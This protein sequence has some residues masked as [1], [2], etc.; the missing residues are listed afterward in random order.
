MNK[1]IC[2]SLLCV[3]LHATA[4][5]PFTGFYVKGS[6]GGTLGIFEFTQ[7]LEAGVPNTTTLIRPSELEVQ[8][9]SFAGLL[10]VG[11]S[12]NF[13]NEWTFGAEITAG[14]T[15]VDVRQDND[16]ILSRP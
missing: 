9:S 11:F 7:T 2:A 5:T 14:L 15:D 3:T 12:Y 8:G 10:G 1:F 16:F 6:L 13:D 4:H